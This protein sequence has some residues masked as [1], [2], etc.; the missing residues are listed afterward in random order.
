MHTHTNKST[1]QIIKKSTRPHTHTHHSTPTMHPRCTTTILTSKVFTGYRCFFGLAYF[2]CLWLVALEDSA[3]SCS[4]FLVPFS[5]SSRPR[6]TQQANGIDYDKDY[7]VSVTTSTTVAKDDMDRD[8][9]DATSTDSIIDTDDFHAAAVS[10]SVSATADYTAG[11]QVKQT[12]QQPRQTNDAPTK[13]I[14]GI[15]HGISISN[16]WIL[17]PENTWGVPSYNDSNGNP[18]DSPLSPAG[19]QQATALGQSLLRLQ[20]QEP[21]QSTF[22][23]DEVELIVVSP[24]TRCLQTYQLAVAEPLNQSNAKKVIPVLAHPWVA[25]RVYTIAEIGRPSLQELQQEFPTVDFSLFETLQHGDNSAN[26]PAASSSS[27][28]SAAAAAAAAVNGEDVKPQSQPRRDQQQQQQPPW[29]YDPTVLTD[30]NR[31]VPWTEW[32][33]HAEGQRYGAHGEPKLVFQRRMDAFQAWLAARPETSILVVAHWG[34]LRHFLGGQELDN[35]QVCRFELDMVSSSSSSSSSATRSEA[36][37]R[38]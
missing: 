8:G 4:A 15:R 16:E 11:A 2:C 23:L 37:T 21:P 7:S 17:Q 19:V 3:W 38:R 6:K 13:T 31:D 36:Q 25:E 18:R 30:F 22:W 10:F 33:P 12:Q 29:W 9:H 27:S 20:R 35:C 26:D 1:R 5:L 14:Y 34:V 28:S 24:L 32:R